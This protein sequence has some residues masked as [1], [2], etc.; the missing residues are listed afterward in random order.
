MLISEALLLAT[1]NLKQQGINSYRIDAL[2]LLCHCLSCSK[3]QIIFNSNLNITPEQE[4][5]FF[6]L[7][8]RRGNK[9]P[10]SHLIGKREF[11]GID[12]TVNNQVLDPRPDSETLVELV[13]DCFPNKNA[14]INILELGVGSGCLSLTILKH[15]P[16][17]C[18][19]GVD[20]SD[21]A[22]K[23][24]QQNADLLG[25]TAQIKLFKSNWFS[26]L[27]PQENFDLIISNPPYIKTDD[28]QFLQDEVKVFEPILA[29]DG[30]RN[31]LDCYQAIA[32]EVMGFLK[33]DGIVILEIGQ[34][35]EQDIIK[36]FT[37]VGLKFIQDKKDLA[38][39]I[40]CLMF[41]K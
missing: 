28:I 1:N 21:Q 22:L 18:G 3:E 2:L 15:F 33:K 6:A 20:I 38:G 12:F 19:T 27:A 36:I 31:G 7:I 8:E 5:Q 34:Y 35:Q 23:M 13:F 16:N 24:S 40:R 41:K 29:L 14:N 37:G 30:G 11:F 17:A 32:Q 39:I 9:E 10:V 25:L 4:Q 26:N